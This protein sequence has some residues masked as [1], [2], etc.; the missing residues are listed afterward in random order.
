MRYVPSHI[1]AKTISG[2]Y[3]SPD[4]K[5]NS[6]SGVESTDEGDADRGKAKREGGARTKTRTEEIAT[7][8]ASSSH[9]C[10]KRSGHRPDLH[11]RL[12]ALAQHDGSSCTE[13]L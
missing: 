12:A 3:A 8:M 2:H 1:D 4:A 5:D 7:S 11:G 9:C 10:C 6:S 13:D